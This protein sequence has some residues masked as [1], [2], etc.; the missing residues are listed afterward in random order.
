[1]RMLGEAGSVRF[2]A[3]LNLI[4][5][6]S[7][8]LLHWRFGSG[9]QMQ[10]RQL[11]DRHRTISFGV[12]MFLAAAVGFIAL[13]YEILWYRIYAF[14]SGGAAPTFAKLLAFYLFGIAYGSLSVRDVCRRKLKDDLPRTL[15]TISSAVMLGSILAYLLAPILARWV[16]H[17]PSEVGF[18]FVFVAAALLGS[19]FPLLSHAAIDPAQDAGRRLSL[20]YLSNILGSTLGS[21]LVGFVVIDHLSTRST[22][23][24]LLSFGLMIAIILTALSQR[25]NV[26]F[27]VGALACAICIACA[28]PLFS[29]LYE[30]L[31]YKTQYRDGITFANLVENRSGVIAVDQSGTVFGGG[32]YDGHFNIDPVNDSNGIFR[33]YAVAGLHPLPKKILVIGLSSGSWAQVVANSPGV[34]DVTIV[35][36]N[37]GYLPL[38]RERAGVATLLQNP[39]VHIVIDDGRRWLVGHP[40]QRFDFIL[41]N[42]T[43]NW[44]SNASNLLSRDFLRLLRGHLA[45]GGIAYYNATW[46]KDVL[47][48]GI[49]QFPYALRIAGF[50]VVSNSPFALDK[51]RWKA[52]LLQYRIDGHRMYVLPRD[53]E[54]LNN[55]LHLADEM[56]LPGAAIGLPNGMLESRTHIL[57]RCRGSLIITDDNMGTE[58]R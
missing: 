28:G 47:E 49:S 41:M 35:E 17:I 43:F 58:W 14:T 25:W 9:S 34:E 38:I 54:S 39:K 27:I 8:L 20:L 15:Q 11:S 13:A 29:H 21:F 18:V 10:E 30:R 16:T 26:N 32:V 57:E 56:D 44:R 24:L 22:S 3:S 55:T 37:P 23:V 50:L 12:G 4:V 48:T 1:M 19:A 33:A 31:L 2:A 6:L 51:D 52:A 40:D 36:I 53:G 45:S 46:S 42:T 7:A 5:G